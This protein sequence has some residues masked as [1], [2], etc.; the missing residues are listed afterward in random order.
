M[1]NVRELL[2]I[3]L[4]KCSISIPD[5]ILVVYFTRERYE[6]VNTALNKIKTQLFPLLMVTLQQQ[7][8]QI[9]CTI[10]R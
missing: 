3:S 2:R 7:N 9:R 5:N 10:I 6:Y 1:A 4:K 8:T